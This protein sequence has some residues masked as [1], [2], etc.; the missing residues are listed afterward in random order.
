VIELLQ[1]Q[2]FCARLQAEM[3]AM[4]S[5]LT[6]VGILSALRFEP[7]G[8]TGQ[9]LVDLLDAHDDRALGGEA[10][11]RIDARHT[12]RLTFRSPSSLTAHL[13]QATLAISSIPQLR[14]LLGDEVERCLLQRICE[15][16]RELCEHV[17][18]IWFIDLS[19]CVGRWEGCVLCVSSIISRS[20]AHRVAGTFEYL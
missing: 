9:G 2:V 17:G 5:A 4:G 10:V 6:A 8:G 3:V 19:R 12:V 13:S 1:Y 20:N 14:Q 15:V 18:G 11:L 7:V 16:G